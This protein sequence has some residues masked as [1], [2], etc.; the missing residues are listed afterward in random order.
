MQERGRNKGNGT[1]IDQTHAHPA[2][3]HV[4][5][6]SRKTG[7]R[8][9]FVIQEARIQ[10]VADIAFSH[11]VQATAFRHLHGGIF[12]RTGNGFTFD[13]RFQQTV[14]NHVAVFTDR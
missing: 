1:I 3:A 12:L 11:T 7:V 6:F 2:A 14:V 5:D 8:T 9:G 10:P 13:N 4:N